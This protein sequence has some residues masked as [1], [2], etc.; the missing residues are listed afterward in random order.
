MNDDVKKWGFFSATAYEKFGSFIWETPEGKEVEVTG[1]THEENGSS[2]KWPDKIPVG[3]VIKYVKAGH[4]GYHK[5]ELKW[6]Y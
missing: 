4:V 2:Y 3:Q 1:I 6:D 5:W